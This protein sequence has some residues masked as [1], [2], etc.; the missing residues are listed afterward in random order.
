MAPREPDNPRR[1]IWSEFNAT[2][3]RLD[4]RSRRRRALGLM[5][6]QAAL[7]QGTGGMLD[8]LPI[9]QPLPK[10]PEIVDAKNQ[11]RSRRGRACCA[12]P[13]CW[14]T[15]SSG[16]F[17]ASRP[18]AGIRR[19]SPGSISC[20]GNRPSAS[21][22]ASTRSPPMP[23]VPQDRIGDPMPGPTLRARLGDIVQ[24]TFVNNINPGQFP[25][26]IDQAEN[27]TRPPNRQ[28]PAAIPARRATRPRPAM[29]FPT[30]STG[31]APA[32]SI[33]TARTPIRTATGDNVFLEVRPSPIVNGKPT[34]TDKTVA[35]QFNDFFKACYDS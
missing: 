20:A 22:A 16:W 17:S 34:V 13:S 8:C 30:A 14:R 29:R 7:A 5:L 11:R 12:A 35:K 2:R 32:T 21:S 6:P 23:L 24:L 10:I 33:S 18:A 1:T 25:Y 26:S 19:A 31:R 27:Q 3:S 9:G 28:R 15:K 4:G